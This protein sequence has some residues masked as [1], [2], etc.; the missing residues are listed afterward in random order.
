MIEVL[1]LCGRIVQKIT[2]K[3]EENLVDQQNN[4]TL[5]KKT[6]I[7][8]CFIVIWRVSYNIEV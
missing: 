4:W 2:P 8:T 7:N 1:E 6:L 5:Q 3:Y